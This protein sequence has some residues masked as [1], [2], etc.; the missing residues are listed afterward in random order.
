MAS[1]WSILLSSP[2]TSLA[3]LLRK[4][5]R[6]AA[7]VGI[8]VARRTFRHKLLVN[9]RKT[10]E[11]TRYEIAVTSKA[12][13]VLDPGS[14]QLEKPIPDNRKQQRHWKNTDVYGTFHGQPVRIEVTVLHESLPG[15]VHLELDDIVKAANTPLGFSVAL[16]TVL[17][18]R[19][20]AERVRA[21]LELL[22]EA[23]EKSGGRDEEIDAIFRWNKGA[24]HCEQTTSPFKSI[25][26][27]GP[28]EFP[29]AHSP[30]DHTPCAAWP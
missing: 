8:D 7:H 4:T 23:H 19:G 27:Y 20:Y 1:G 28:D 6:L 26:L 5:S 12:C 30:G 15:V 21:A 2:G 11:D 22:G 13:A 25:V 9:D 17:L 10:L 18:D 29:A 3:L 14:V 24:Y 16:R